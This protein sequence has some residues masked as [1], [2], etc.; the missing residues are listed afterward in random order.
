[1][2]KLHIPE[3][4][5]KNGDVHKERNLTVELVDTLLA[6]FPPP[7]D[8]IFKYYG[9]PPTGAFK[10]TEHDRLVFWDDDVGYIIMP[11]APQNRKLWSKI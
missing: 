6:N 3:W 9:V 10:A 2:Y 8:L 11:N 5:D 4:T 7:P 1:M